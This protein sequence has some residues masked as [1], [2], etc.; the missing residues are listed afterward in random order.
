MKHT[1]LFYLAKAEIEA[2]GK[3]SVQPDK[4]RQNG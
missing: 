3:L 2:D 4:S 1:I